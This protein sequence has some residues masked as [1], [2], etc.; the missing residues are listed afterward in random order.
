MNPIALMLALL[1]V[2][3]GVRL[4]QPFGTGV[5]AAGVAVLAA[6]FWLLPKGWH[7]R[8]GRG[9]WA[10]QARVVPRA[11]RDK[12]TGQPLAPVVG[13]GRSGGRGTGPD[14]VV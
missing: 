14:P 1:H 11:G 8:E 4:L 7:V 2:Y 9:P 10:V 6:C 3:I 5:Q 12:G 13:G